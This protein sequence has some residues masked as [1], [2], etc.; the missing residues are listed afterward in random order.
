MR[1]LRYMLVSLMS[2]TMLVSC[3]HKDLCYINRKQCQ[4]QV[5]FDWSETSRQAQSMRVFFY[6]IDG[7]AQEPIVYDLQGHSGGV[8]TLPT[9]EYHVVSYNTDTENVLYHYKMNSSGDLDLL[10]TTIPSAIA[11]NFKISP[12]SGASNVY[13]TPDW[14][15]RGE[16]SQPLVITPKECGSERI[17]TITP[18]EALYYCDYEIR[19]IQNLR[20]TATYPMVA[21]LSNVSR[22][23]WLRQGLCTD[24]NAQM[25]LEAKSSE[26]KVVGACY[27]FGVPNGQ[28]QLLTLYVHTALGVQ[29]RTFDVTKQIPKLDPKDHTIK[30]HLLIDTYWELPEPIGG[31][32][33]AFNPDVE[34]WDDEEQDIDL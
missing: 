16:L 2:L 26:G 18:E 5:L 6:P 11:R 31:S 27:L 9:G 15:C 25:T 30:I 8:V 21:S 1:R 3:V 7:S 34:G 17:I 12:K 4:V 20:S 10:L 33:G 28:T 22:G 13:E 19:G 24:I 29:S 32:G 23:L 14:L